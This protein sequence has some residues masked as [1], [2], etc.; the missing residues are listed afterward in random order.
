[1]QVISSNAESEP[2]V[3]Q[4]DCLLDAIAGLKY[5]MTNL[6]PCKVGIGSMPHPLQVKGTTNVARCVTS[7]ERLSQ[8]L[9][10]V[11][12]SKVGTAAEK[13][14]RC[15]QTAS[16]HSHQNLQDEQ[17]GTA[18]TNLHGREAWRKA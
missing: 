3:T 7:G 13:K 8:K 14:S 1:M 15:K 9:I 5:P 18:N 10:Q 12:Q 16:K 17:K 6:V 11:H 2:L 4:L